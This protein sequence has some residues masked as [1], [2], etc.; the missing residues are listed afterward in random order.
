MA[1]IDLN[2]D[3]TI[4]KALIKQMN[5]LIDRYF[6]DEIDLVAIL[7]DQCRA[8]SRRDV[9]QRFDISTQYLHDILNGNRGISPMIARQL[10]YERQVKFVLVDNALG[11]T[12]SITTDNP[13]GSATE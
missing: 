1:R 3:M 13:T 5:A 8:T 12:E 9:A 11:T 2:I 7:Y 6:L 10:G 4:S